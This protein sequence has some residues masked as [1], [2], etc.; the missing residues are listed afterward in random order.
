VEDAMESKIRFNPQTKE[1][2]IEGSQEFVENYFQR[3][4]DLLASLKETPGKAV[5]SSR[6]T[7]DKPVRVKKGKIF[8]TVVDAIKAS[9][10]G[11]STPDLMKATNFRQLQIRSVIFKAA[12][13]GVIKT[14]KR[15]VYKAEKLVSPSGNPGFVTTALPD[16]K[17]KAGHN[18]LGGAL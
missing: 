14:V 15:G 16:V 11:M 5:R 17:K 2:E 10:H 1:V 7:A 12:K 9:D 18:T 3:I 13:M 4:T 8:T 6:K